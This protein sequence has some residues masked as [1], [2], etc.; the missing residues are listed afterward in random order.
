MSTNSASAGKAALAA[1]IQKTGAAPAPRILSYGRHSLSEEDIAAVLEVLRGD[2]LTQGPAVPR[3]EAAL[4]DYVGA[5][6][7][8]AVSSGT[9]A[10]HLACLA[11]GLGP[12][13]A[14]ITQ[15]LTFAASAN[16]MIYCGARPAFAD[17]DAATLGLSGET[18]R[19]GLAAAP[20]AKVVIPVAYA[21]LSTLDAAL[22][23]AAGGRMII[24]DGCH[25]LGGTRPDGSKAGAGG[26]AAMTCFSFHP[27]KPITTGDGGA[28]TT[29]DDD[30]AHRLRLLRNHGVERDAARFSG[31][32]R[33]PWVY[34][35]QALG[36]NYRMTDIQA[37]LG[38]S[39]MARLDD[40]TARRRAIAA[41]YD[42]ALAGLE[43]VAPVQAAPEMRTRS[44]C[45]LYAVRIDFA[46]LGRT[47]AEVMQALREDG[48][49]TQ[50][51]YIPVYKHPFHR[52]HVPDGV[53]RCANTEAY[54]AQALSLPCF[55]D[56]TDA[57]VEHVAMALARTLGLG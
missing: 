55:P 6:H 25:A 39:Q 36:F 2:F 48:I 21:G 56:M 31:E 41:L 45:H 1:A 20:E 24:E 11:A 27:V 8:I 10:L 53:A 14:G 28:I 18:L 52:D 49:G 26:L 46:K 22:A 43:G 5:R 23:Q 3:F 9:A 42:A 7:A 54:Y 44:S 32:E 19:A 33:G 13:D 29:D 34:E 17:V 12:G 57:D 51:H 4:A 40:F 50:V 15:P 16:C 38:V 37:A 35:Q 47:R 30:L